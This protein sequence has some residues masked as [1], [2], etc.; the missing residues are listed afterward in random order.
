MRYE[1]KTPYF[2]IDKS[3]LDT[4]LNKLNSA[5]QDAWNNYIIGYSY[6]TNELPWFIEYFKEKGCYAEVVSDDEYSLAVSIGVSKEKFIYNGIAKSKETFLEAVKNHA[7]VNTDSEYEIEWLDSLDRV[8]SF[9]DSEFS[10]LIE[11]FVLEAGYRDQID[12]DIIENNGQHYISE[13]NPRFG[14]DDHMQLILNN[15]DGVVT[16]KI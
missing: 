7:I 8:V 12:I 15:L 14:G 5:L 2:L 13:V 9:K 10:F 1:L 11:K 6:K 4:G 16:S 3:D